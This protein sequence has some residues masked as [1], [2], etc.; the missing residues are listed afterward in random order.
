M[1]SSGWQ[2]QKNFPYNHS[3]IACDVNIT[4]IT[5]SGDTL[6]VSGQVAAVYRGASGGYA[7]YYYPVYVNVENSG[8]QTLLAGYERVYGT[9]T[10][11]FNCS[12]SCAA[13]RTSAELWVY[14]DMNNGAN[15]GTLAWMLYFDASYQQPGQPTV[16]IKE[17]YSNG[18]KFG[19]SGN[20]GI[21]SSA[22]GRYIEAAI[23]NQST[24]GSTY[25]F[26][27]ASNTSS[28]DI[29][30]T[31]TNYAGGGLTIQSNKQYWYG[32]YINNTQGSNSK[33][34]GQFVTKAANPEATFTNIDG[35]AI[36]L[37][38][39]TAAD[40]GYYTKTVGVS[41]DGTNYT[42]LGT[43]SDGNAHSG[44]E[45]IDNLTP[46]TTYSIRVRSATTAGNSVSTT[47]RTTL[48][49]EPTL[50]VTSQTINSITIGYAF[51]A[52]G[53]AF[54]KTLA[55]TIDGGTNWV[56]AATISGGSAASGAFTISNLQPGHA[57]NLITRVTTGAGT[58]T[59]DDMAISTLPLEKH[60]IYGPV[61]E[62]EIIGVTGVVRSGGSGQI[63]SFDANTFWTAAES[64]IDKTKTMDYLMVVTNSTGSKASITLY[65]T[66]SSNTYLMSGTYTDYPT[67]G[68]TVDLAH[69][70]T[71]YIDLTPTLGPS[72][73]YS[74]NRVIEF[75][76]SANSQA[77]R[78]TKLYGSA[79][80][81]ILTGVTGTIRAGSPGI[82]AGMQFDSTVFWNKVKN[83]IDISKTMDYLQQF[84][85]HGGDSHTLTLFYTDGTSYAFENGAY[86][87]ENL[88][89]IT[90]RGSSDYAGFDY[91][92]L[93]PTYTTGNV[94]KLIHQG[95]GH[96]PYYGHIVYY[97][98]A[99]HTATG[100]IL[101]KNQSQINQL[102]GSWQGWETEIEGVQLNSADI[103]EVYIGKQA[104][105]IPQGFLIACSSIDTVD[106]SESEITSIPINFLSYC[107]NFNGTL[108]LPPTAQTIGSLFLYEAK[109]FNQPLTIPTGVTS[110]N[111]N[112]LYNASDFNQPITLPPSLV[113]LGYPFL[114]GCNMMTSTVNVGSLSAD[115]ATDSER[116]FATNS[117]SAAMY[118]TGVTIAGA[119]RA[120]WLA[121]FPNSNSVP[122][123]KLVDAGY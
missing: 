83:V 57:Y 46:N 84:V 93:T 25:R 38:W 82:S 69:A 36:D 4:G 8:T 90:Y 104:E 122:F 64:S 12:F 58:I 68:I 2:G 86:V 10:V 40:G 81:P 22:S 118:R 74:A 41:L 50:S 49:A 65:Y 114:Y 34:T 51:D 7:Y 78:I 17:I 113:S 21:P 79:E 31:N 92:D 71:D 62:T 55:Y 19:V 30:V 77:Q 29:A 117:S 48:P 98:D 53:G 47:S 96:F 3:D 100:V 56:Q 95:F 109:H 101:L 28:A 99:G 102:H 73:V 112:F 72:G 61:A 106:L 110:I 16:T 14:V 9:K 45:L 43:Y 6:Y 24:Y 123:R 115:I 52:D 91:I 23:L 15:K 89:G 75:Y 13:D 97:T 67:Y 35:T 76:G 54:D 121:K 80:G 111:Y 94:A 18:A 39:S 87:Y 11:D 59:L 88:Y 33:V 63:V 120:A 116:T 107:S 119:N 66:D 37:A 26:N 108:K 85:G 27:T 105:S 42:T 32:G 70:G 44:Y 20:Y 60:K 1:A 103:K 5:H